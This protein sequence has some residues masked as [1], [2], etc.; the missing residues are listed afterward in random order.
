MKLCLRREGQDADHRGIWGITFNGRNVGTARQVFPAVAMNEVMNPL[1]I[2]GNPAIVCHPD[3]GYEIDR[4]LPS[5]LLIMQNYVCI[6]PGVSF[7]MVAIR[8]FSAQTAGG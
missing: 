4:H 1:G 7:S 8:T 5:P 3:V 2:C 6:A